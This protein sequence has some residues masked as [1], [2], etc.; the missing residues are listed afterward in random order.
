MFPRILQELKC[1]FIVPPKNLTEGVII[2]PVLIMDI[3]S[4][5]A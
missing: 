1:L 4:Q 2:I 3:E 5:R